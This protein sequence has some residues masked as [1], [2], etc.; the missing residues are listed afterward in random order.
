MANIAKLWLRY[1]ADCVLKHV[2]L[3]KRFNGGLYE[4]KLILQKLSR[5][6]RSI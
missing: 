2:G 6:L 5:F 4:F 1:G 3:R